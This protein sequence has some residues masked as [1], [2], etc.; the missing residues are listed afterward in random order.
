MYFSWVI[1]CTS[2]HDSF[3]KLWNVKII[4][5]NNYSNA[6]TTIQPKEI[7]CSTSTHVDY[8]N[9]CLWYT[10][11]FCNIV[12]SSPKSNSSII[13]SINF[14]ICINN[15]HKTNS[16]KEDEWEMLQLPLEPQ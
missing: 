6:K 2:P 14:I 7:I 4:N 5:S 16:R 15:E 13:F 3:Y 8:G 11:L 1:M 10:M 12:E 9:K